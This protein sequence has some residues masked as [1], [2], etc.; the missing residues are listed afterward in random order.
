MAAAT[1]GHDAVVASL[2]RT[3]R[4]TF[5]RAQVWK[6]NHQ[7]Q[8]GNT[9]L[10]VAAARG[11]VGVVRALLTYGADVHV[12]NQAKDSAL[13]VAAACGHD[14]IVQVFVD[15]GANLNTLNAK[16]ETPLICAI[17]AHH[18]STTKV[19]LSLNADVKIDDSAAPI[20]IAVRD[21]DLEAAQSHL[22]NC[23][24][25]NTVDEEGNT[26]VHLAIVGNHFAILQMLLQVDEIAIDIKNKMGDTPMKLAIK[27]CNDAFVA[28]LDAKRNAQP[29]LMAVSHNLRLPR[30]TVVLYDKQLGRRGHAVVYAG[31]YQGRDVAVKEFIDASP[32]SMARE[33]A[34]M[35]KCDHLQQVASLTSQTC[36]SP[37][38]VDLV[39]VSKSITG[40]PVLLLEYMDMENVSTISTSSATTPTRRF[41]ELGGAL[42]VA[43]AVEYLHAKG[44]VHRDIKL[45]NVLLSR[46]FYIKLGD[47]GIARVANTT[48]TSRVG[49]DGYMAP[50]VVKGGHYSTAADIYSFGVLMT[51]LFA[52]MPPWCQELADACMSRI[53]SCRPKA[54]DVVLRIKQHCEQELRQPPPTNRTVLPQKDM[55]H[56]MSLMSK[57]LGQMA[58]EFQAERYKTYEDVVAE[59]NENHPEVQLVAAAARGDATTVEAHLKNGVDASST[60]LLGQSAL[61]AAIKNGHDAIALRLLKSKADVCRAHAHLIEAMQQTLKGNIQVAKMNVLFDRI[62]RYNHALHLLGLRRTTPLA[63]AE[64]DSR[65]ARAFA[66]IQAEGEA[67]I[68]AIRCGDDTAVAQLVLNKSHVNVNV[69]DRLGNT[70][71]HWAVLLERDAVLVSLLSIDGIATD[72]VNSS[73]DTPMSLAMR[74]GY[75]KAVEALHQKHPREVPKIEIGDFETTDEILGTGASGNVVRGVFMGQAVAVKSMHR[76]SELATTKRCASA[77]IL[78]P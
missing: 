60:D 16:S 75:I 12:V 70:A 23:S 37:Y 2:L 19:L 29:A 28:A 61:I 14:L 9:L 67:L 57:K 74:R 11:F 51:K 54:S 59:F 58:E 8:D 49:T 36:S 41:P 69:R 5:E 64:K 46:N 66:A 32:E 42:G 22:R 45:S 30:P 20:L 63:L 78:A 38:I 56:R 43:K 6:I 71:L 39:A 47:F 27:I 18:T 4:D 62:V 21:G 40:R 55:L 13:H 3:G 44:F 73:G 77:Y 17:T 31:K 72:V 25:I 68:V 65:M 53:P 1:A 24:N 52:Q 50:E 76:D 7:D 34:V 48:M 35:Q 33:V 15:A 26:V 10:H